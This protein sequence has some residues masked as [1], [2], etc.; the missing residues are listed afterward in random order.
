MPAFDIQPK[1]L[2]GAGD[3]WNAGDM[4]GEVIGLSDDLR[5]M[6]ANAVTAYYISDPER[7]H[8]AKRDLIRF[9]DEVPLKP[10][11]KIYRGQK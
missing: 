9:L 2:T 4:F 10:V 1:R 5:L 8:P 7:R 6:L 11:S 3:A